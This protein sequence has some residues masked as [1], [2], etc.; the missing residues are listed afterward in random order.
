[1]SFSLPA[2]APTYGSQPRLTKYELD[3]ERKYQAGQV[4]QGIM[5]TKPVPNASSVVEN[6]GATVEMGNIPVDYTGDLLTTPLIFT[7]ISTGVI[8]FSLK[9]AISNLAMKT[10]TGSSLL[11]AHSDAHAMAAGR[12]F[13]AVKVAAFLS[14][15]GSSAPV[16]PP[17]S[18][19]IGPDTG[20]NSEKYV[21]YQTYLDQ[22][23]TQTDDRYV[24]ANSNQKGNVILDQKAGNFFY[25]DKKTLPTGQV[26]ILANFESRFIPVSS[27]GKVFQVLESYDPPGGGGTTT[28]LGSYALFN[29]FEALCFYEFVP[30]EVRVWMDGSNNNYIFTTQMGIACN[31]LQPQ[32]AGIGKLF[33]NPTTG[34]P[35]PIA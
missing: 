30:L 10:S 5:Q 17:I 1:M 14:L 16:L 4:L 33:L 35:Y 31:I 29:H 25:V 3:I 19:L 21:A 18:E 7:Q 2:W 34:K 23:V 27:S 22:F 12:A 6:I 20:L 15:D 28:A 9:T 26:S 24:T 32:G 13:D 8:G 11:Q